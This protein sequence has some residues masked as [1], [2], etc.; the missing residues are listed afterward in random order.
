[1]LLAATEQ[2]GYR[3]EGL[4]LGLLLMIV[5]QILRIIR[6]AVTLIESQ[7]VIIAVCSRHRDKFRFENFCQAF[8]MALEYLL[9]DVG[10][11]RMI[12]CAYNLFFWLTVTA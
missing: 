8:A 11:L 7:G 1:M 3:A 12:E 2:L 10:G 9:D 4:F 5:G 6:S